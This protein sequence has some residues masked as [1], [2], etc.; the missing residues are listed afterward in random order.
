MNDSSVSTGKS[1]PSTP[2]AQRLL[3]LDALRGFDMFWIVG[4]EEIVHA[5]NKVSQTG[6]TGML[7]NQLSHRDWVGVAFYDLIF[8]LFVFIVGVSLVFSLSRSLEQTGKAA[9]CRKILWRAGLLYLIGILCY[10]GIGEGVEKI[11]LLGVLQRIALAYLGAGLLF[12]N[13][14]VRGLIIACVALLVG[15]WALMTFVSVPGVGAGNFAEGKNLANY[16]DHQYLP[17]RKWDGDHD[18]EGLLSTLPAIGTCLLGVFA[19]LFLKHQGRSEQ[20]KVNWLL[21]AG[22]AGVVL[23][24]LW[25]LQFPVIKKV[26]TSSYVLVAGGYSCLFLAVFYQVIEIW[27]YQKWAMPF[28]WIG[29]NPI[30]IYLAH[31]LI[32]FRTLAERF[33]GGPVKASLGNYGELLVT[34]VAMSFTFLVVNFLYRRKI[35]LRL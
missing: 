17:F 29:V 5:L 14:R 16:I 1:S 24:F 33:V 11:R 3:S 31:N 30:T 27:K 34:L 18:P 25:G 6:L 15:Y 12:V 28:V 8:P 2:L 23:G 22:A 21:A 9:T 35:F 20:Q 10:G 13:L 32:N 19:G 7:A 26:W 4:A